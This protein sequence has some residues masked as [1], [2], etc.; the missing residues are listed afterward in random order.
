[1]GVP[2]RPLPAGYRPRIAHETLYYQL[3]RDYWGSLLEAA[4]GKLPDHVK[5][6]FE[7]F[8]DCGVLSKG[9]ARLRCPEC[10]YDLAVPFS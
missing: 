8:L 2:C 1:M 10:G 6:A 5:R 3:V 7:A 4:Q 9:F